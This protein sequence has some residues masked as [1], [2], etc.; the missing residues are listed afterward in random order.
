VDSISSIN[1]SEDRNQ[2]ESPQRV[3]LRL[4]HIEEES[5]TIKM[6]KIFNFME[7]FEEALIL[8]MNGI[9]GDKYHYSRVGYDRCT[10]TLS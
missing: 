2:S 3:K 1:T 9:N 10:I 5:F 8:L 4:H 7:S 6:P